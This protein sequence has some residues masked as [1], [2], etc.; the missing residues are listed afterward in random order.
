MK[1]HSFLSFIQ[2][3]YDFSRANAILSEENLK[4]GWKHWLTL[5]L[6]HIYNSSKLNFN[7]QTNAHYPSRSR[8]GK[9]PSYLHY[10]LDKA[11]EV[12]EKKCSASRSDFMVEEQGKVNFFEIRCGNGHSLFKNKDLLKFEADIARVEALK[13]VNP[14]LEMTVLF[15]FYGAFS[16]KQ[17]EAFIAIDNSIRCTYL[18]DSR[19]QGSSS[20]SRMTHM[21]RE[22]EARLCLAAF[23]V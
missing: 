10:H 18:L 12:V 6:L 21:Q 7:I 15:A 11:V 22:G 14:A 3:N 9:Q 17:V 8:D 13:K 19:L 4:N 2:S 1:A 5:E 20:I 16:T 23:S